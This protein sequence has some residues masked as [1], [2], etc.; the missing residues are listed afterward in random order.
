MQSALIALANSMLALCKYYRVL[1][2]FWESRIREKPG[3]WTKTCLTGHRRPGSSANLVTPS[4]L[5]AQGYRFE[6][7]VC[8]PLCSSSFNLT[9]APP[10]PHWVQ[11]LL[12]L[13]RSCKWDVRITFHFLKAIQICM[14]QK[15]S[16]VLSWVT[17][18]CMIFF[19]ERK[20]CANVKK[21]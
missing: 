6:H 10:I 20:M 1:H 13:P 4:G 17:I 12:S 3:S 2:N 8:S 7:T 19:W 16:W 5:M 21:C 15:Y 11:E 18:R 9:M 14:L